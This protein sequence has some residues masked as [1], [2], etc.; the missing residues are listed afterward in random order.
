MEYFLFQERQKE[1]HR[2]QAKKEPAHDPK[3]RLPELPDPA[4]DQAYAPMYEQRNKLR[5]VEFTPPIQHGSR[6]FQNCTS[7]P[8]SQDSDE[9]PPINIPATFHNY[10]NQTDEH[11]MHGGYEND[12]YFV[13]ETGDRISR[14]YYNMGGVN[15]KRDE[16]G[17][18]G[19][20]HYV[21]HAPGAAARPSKGHHTPGRR[22][23][24]SPDN[25]DHGY[26]QG[27]PVSNPYLN[28]KG[29]KGSMN[30][31]SAISRYP[32]NESFYQNA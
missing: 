6:H 3:G 19:D 8:T 21:P 20:D 16:R 32:T 27:R 10:V 22:Q 11:H 2:Q 14:D 4:M 18:T 29:S 30:N 23:H 1:K 17:Y 13:D 31:P 25:S 5:G 24:S 15:A 12:G 26:N 28:M 9:D 7:E